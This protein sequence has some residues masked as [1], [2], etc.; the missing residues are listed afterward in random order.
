MQ[1]TII[2]REEHAYG[3]RTLIAMRREPLKSGLER[4]SPPDVLGTDGTSSS[5][6][7]FLLY[8]LSCAR[9]ARSCASLE[10]RRSGRILASSTSHKSTS[11]KERTMSALSKS[12]QWPFAA[13]DPGKEAAAGT[14]QLRGIV[15]DVDG[16]L[17]KRTI[18]TLLCHTRVAIYHETVPGQ[19][20]PKSTTPQLLYQIFI[21]V[22]APSL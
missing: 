20:N 18:T 12:K 21:T 4:K 13:L 5:F 1:N 17:C 22:L 8:M 3:I 2:A 7:I 15:F 6:L 10:T 14:K 11:V 16:T 19:Q 9:F